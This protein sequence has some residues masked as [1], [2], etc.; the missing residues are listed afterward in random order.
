MIGYD[1]TIAE[2]ETTDPYDNPTHASLI[3]CHAIALL[4]HYQEGLERIATNSDGDWT[5][6]FEFDGEFEE[7]ARKTLEGPRDE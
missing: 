1:E 4:K 2:L 5:W 3:M 7:Y 6:P